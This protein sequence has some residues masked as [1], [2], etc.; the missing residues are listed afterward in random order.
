M[1]V[2][3]DGRGDALAPLRAGADALLVDP[4]GVAVLVQLGLDQQDKILGD[5]VVLLPLALVGVAQEDG[6]GFDSL[7]RSLKLE[8]TVVAVMTAAPL[9][10]RTR[11]SA[12]RA[13][14]GADVCHL[15]S[16]P[17]LS[18]GLQML[19]NQ[20]HEALAKASHRVLRAEVQR[21]EF[22]LQLGYGRRVTRGV[23]DLSA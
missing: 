14:G 23:C 8:L 4:H 16:G 19:T 12:T 18:A 20:R 9:A 15:D 7:G 17:S 10:V 22:V 21:G 6:L 3:Q 11:L 13:V 1:R 5:V 2:L